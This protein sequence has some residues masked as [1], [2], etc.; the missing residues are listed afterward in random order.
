[1]TLADYTLSALALWECAGESVVTISLNCDFMAAGRAGHWINGEGQ[2]LK[3]TGS[4]VFVQGQLKQAE[5]CL[6]SFTGV[7]KRLQKRD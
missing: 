1:M 7:V 6:L 2:V 4:M 5:N 3:K